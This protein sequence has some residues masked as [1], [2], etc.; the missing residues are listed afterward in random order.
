MM[1]KEEFTKILN[2][3]T[4]GGGFIALKRY[5]IVILRTRII[6]RE[7]ISKLLFAFNYL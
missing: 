4:P 1:T 3:R 7:D 2:F 6:F 5:Y